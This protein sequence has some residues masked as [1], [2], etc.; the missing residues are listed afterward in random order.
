ML[1]TERSLCSPTEYDL[2]GCGFVLQSGDLGNRPHCAA[3]IKLHFCALWGEC[4]TKHRVVPVGTYDCCVHS[5]AATF[6]V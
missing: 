4:M 2:T 1:N 5:A 3:M 6:A